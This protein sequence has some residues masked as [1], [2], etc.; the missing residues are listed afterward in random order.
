MKMCLAPC[1]KGCTDERYAEEAAAVE[2]FLAT[3]GESRLVALRA[4]RDQASADLAF[5]SAAALARAGAARRE[6]CTL[7]LP[8][9]CARSAAC[10]R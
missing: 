9:S 7:S 3:R 6:P 10:A 5:E 8:N 2:N 1:Y 4:Q